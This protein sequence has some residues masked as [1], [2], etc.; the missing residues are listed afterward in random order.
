MNTGNNGRPSLN[1]L[2]F[3]GKGASGKD[4]QANK[5]IEGNPH[6]RRFST[7]EAIRDIRS[8]ID[9]PLHDSIEDFYN[10]HNEGALLSDNLILKIV[11]D[12]LLNTIK[13]KTE[14]TQDEPP[15]EVKP[16]IDTIIFTG[17]PRTEGQLDD[18]DLMLED[19]A[20]VAG[21]EGLKTNV[22]HVYFDISDEV[23]RS[24]AA[25]RLAKDK[26]EGNPLRGDDDPIIVEQ[27]LATFRENTQPMINRLA[28]NGDL[29]KIDASGN[30][31][32]VAELTREALGIRPSI[33]EGSTYD[34]ELTPPSLPTTSRR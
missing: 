12:A 15:T 33:V 17:Y 25:G 6:A 22:R 19:V 21:E 4:T 9:H 10:T 32:E 11:E 3:N 34:P 28:D 7:G 13:P 2:F 18:L 14:P 27:R 16:Y 31:E 20:T 8:N 26:K 29:I 30:V 5:L 23:S 1:L 24:R